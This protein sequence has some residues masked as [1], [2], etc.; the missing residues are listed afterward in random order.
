MTRAA[1]ARIAGITFLFYIAVAFPSMVLF[2]RATNAE[3]TAAILAHVSEHLFE[4]R[5]AIILTL[6]SSFAA[7]VLGVTLY[8]ITRDEDHE[9]AILA[10]ACR[11]CEGFVGAFSLLGTVSL[12]W[13]ARAGSGPDALDAA[14]ANTLG[15]VLLMPSDSPTVSATFFAVGSTLFSYLLL[16]GRTIPAPLAWLGVFASILLVIGLPLKLVGL[17]EG[18]VTTLMW[19]PMAV[20]EIPLGFWLL[21]KGV[22]APLA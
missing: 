10:L 21:I 17:L 4:L 15:E 20:F 2:N 5:A 19:I 13:L 22:P 11:L 9:L 7:V 16:R 18:P 1:N 14:T 3:G 8:G 6:L 12:L